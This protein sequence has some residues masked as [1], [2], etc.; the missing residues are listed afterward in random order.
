[1]AGPD[2]ST[3]INNFTLDVLKGGIMGYDDLDVAL[4]QTLSGFSKVDEF[5]GDTVEQIMRTTRPY[6]SEAMIE[7]KDMPEGKSWAYLRTQLRNTQ[8]MTNSELTIED[9]QRARGGSD[10]WGDIVMEALQ[11]QIDDRE[12]FMKLASIGDGTGR[13]GKIKADNATGVT[14]DTNVFT[15]ILSN[16][17]DNF[18][19]DNCWLLSVGMKVD[20]RDASGDALGAACNGLEITS[21]TQGTRSLSGHAAVDGSFTFTSTT[22]LIGS[23][24]LLENPSGFLVYMAGS[25]GKIATSELTADTTTVMTGL[26]GIVTDNVI[27][28]SGNHAYF[29]GRARASF[30]ALKAQVTRLNSGTP[31]TWDG[32]TISTAIRS[33]T[34]G[35][36]RVKPSDLVIMCN[37]QIAMAMH[38]MNISS[39]GGAGAY[40]VS[41]PTGNAAFQAVTGS[42]YSEVFI[43]PDG[44]PIPIVIDDTIPP[45]YMFILH[46]PSFTLY[47]NYW[48]F[49]NDYG[50]GIWQ[51]KRMSRALIYEAPWRGYVQLGVDRCDGCAVI[52]DLRYDL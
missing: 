24:G 15:V 26:T 3:L 20:I 27:F 38:N 41:V 8:F 48:G 11:L 33:L 28:G 51:P 10:S 12:H 44:T 22:D 37:G 47:K 34:T 36:T 6:T 1:M 43:A 50:T 29:Q 19:W 7:R 5:H 35:I 49:V 32:T 2:Y 46:K 17:Y 45:H 4:F 31:T 30:P 52:S 18:G 23:G 21:V 39:T 42:R 9:M 14:E 16:T 13:L 40:Q 25:A